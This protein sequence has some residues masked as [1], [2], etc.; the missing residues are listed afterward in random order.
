M[1]KLLKLRD[2]MRE[3]LLHGSIFPFWQQYTIDEE[4]GGFYG[5]VT[6]DKEIQ[7]DAPKGLVLNAR[8]LWTFAGAYRIFGDPAYKALADRAFDYIVKYFWDEKN[9]GGY[10]MLNA[11]GTVLDDTK[12][13]YGQGFLLY[14]F[15]S[16][17]L[18]RKRIARQHPDNTAEPE[19]VRM[20]SEMSADKLNRQLPNWSRLSSYLRRRDF[21]LYQNTRV[22][23]FP[24]GEQLINDILTRVERAEHFIFLE[25][26]I[27]AEGQLW[28]RMS[29]ALCEKAKSGVEVK[30]IFDDFGNIRRFSGETIERLRDAGVEVF[31]FN[32]VQQYVN[33]L[34]FNYRDHR[35]ICCVDGDFA[36]TG[37]VNIADE[38]ANLF[39]RFGYWKDG[40]VRLEGEGAWGLTTAFINMCGYLGGE[41]H[42]ERDYYRPHAAIKSEGFC[43]PF[44]DGPHNNPDNP[45]EDVYLQM[46]SNAKRFLYITTPYFIPDAS[47]MRALCIAGD[48]GVDVR[49][50]LPGT[51]DHWYTDCV[52][53]SY[54]G[55]LLQHGI[56]IYRYTPGFLHAKSVMVDREIAFVGSVNA[57]YRSFQLNFECGVVTYGTSMIEDLLEDMDGIMD[58]SHCIT[59]EEWRKRPWGRRVL[60]SLLRLV[61]IWL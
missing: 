27:I 36:Y 21:L 2:E 29:T 51:P 25:Y 16:G 5:A 31:V 41:L 14:A 45:A 56:K 47:M 20:R 22:T 39:E 37:G 10:W 15:W 11:D 12:M 32:P 52:A 58:R 18:Q 6:V 54:F 4:N 42:N 55:E 38:Y 24:E 17:S 9:G 1:E 60:E 3:D 48:G 44:V 13:T 46:V 26:F 61:A 7:K 8:L 53:E 59:M 50:M 57:D 49:L 43:Q 33:R 19:S 35:K 30:V 28:D 34:Y 40:G 23:Y